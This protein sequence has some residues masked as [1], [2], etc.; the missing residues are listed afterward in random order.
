MAER[1]MDSCLPSSVIRGGTDYN[2]EGLLILKN[3]SKA[4][5]TYTQVP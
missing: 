2:P 5:C 1:E 3:M 4:I